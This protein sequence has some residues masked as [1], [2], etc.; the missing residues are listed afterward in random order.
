[1]SKDDDR[2]L[3]ALAEYMMILKRDPNDVRVQLRVAELS[4]RAGKNK[5]AIDSYLKVARIFTDQGF[6]LKA[7]PVYKMVLHIDE[8]CIEAKEGLRSL[9][10]QLGLE[11]DAKNVM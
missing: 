5:E 10:R 9:Y 7:L 2:L 1:M 6:F 3:K 8:G 11:E 4:T